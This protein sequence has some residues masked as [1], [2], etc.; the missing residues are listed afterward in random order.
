MVDEMPFTEMKK[1]EGELVIGRAIRLFLE[2]GGKI[3]SSPVCI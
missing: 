1:S 2:L 3:K